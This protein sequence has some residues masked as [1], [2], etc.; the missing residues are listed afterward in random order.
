MKT[1][2]DCCKN[3]QLEVT[4]YNRVIFSCPKC[5][6]KWEIN[7]YENEGRQQEIVRAVSVVKD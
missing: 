6:I 3:G 7:V 4:K 5:Y 2:C 1:T